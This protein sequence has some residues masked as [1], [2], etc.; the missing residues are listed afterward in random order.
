MVGREGAVQSPEDE[1]NELNEVELNGGVSEA[2]RGNTPHSP[3]SQWTQFYQK[4]KKKN[5][6]SIATLCSRHT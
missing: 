2:L 1:M 4:N 5:D 3:T 6:L